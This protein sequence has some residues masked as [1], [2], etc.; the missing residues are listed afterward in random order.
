MSTEDGLVEEW[1]MNYW[2][3]QR[4]CGGVLQGVW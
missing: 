1:C 3:F 2:R 4:L